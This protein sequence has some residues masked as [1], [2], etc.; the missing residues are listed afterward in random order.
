MGC[1]GAHFLTLFGDSFLLF[2]PLEQ[3]LLHV[4]VEL[5]FDLGRLLYCLAVD[6]VVG[7]PSGPVPRADLVEAIVHLKQRQVVRTAIQEALSV[8]QRS[9]LESFGVLVRRAAHAIV[10]D[11][12]N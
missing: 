3:D 10:E 8:L 5:C 12:L 1:R 2:K 4:V 9:I 7:A 6:E 11:I